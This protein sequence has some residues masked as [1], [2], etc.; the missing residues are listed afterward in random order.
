MNMFLSL[1]LSF[2]SSDE[3]Q[4]LYG[5]GVV[6]YDYEHFEFCYYRPF[7]LWRHCTFTIQNV[8]VSC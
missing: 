7:T 6:C 1:L 8:S 5:V 4:F 3:N 2:I